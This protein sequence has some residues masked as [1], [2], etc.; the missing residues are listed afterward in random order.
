MDNSNSYRLNNGRR[1]SLTVVVC[2]SLARRAS[3]LAHRSDAVVA[4][5]CKYR[6]ATHRLVSVSNADV[7]YMT[8][9][10]STY[11]HLPTSARHLLFGF[12]HSISLT[13]FR[14]V[15]ISAAAAYCACVARSLTSGLAR[16]VWM[17]VT[18]DEFFIA[19]EDLRR[20]GVNSGHS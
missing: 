1:L 17:R 9:C 3:L 16:A 5:T 11:W 10:N 15:L 8:T 14:L 18:I 19:G 20:L 13:W 2:H 7:K 12:P 4:A 6:I